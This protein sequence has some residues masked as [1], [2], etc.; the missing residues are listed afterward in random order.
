MEQATARRRIWG[1][2]FYDWAAQPFNTLIL[3]FI[4]AP[5][6]A[7]SVTMHFMES[8][9]SEESAKAQAQSL[10]SLSLTISGL[11]MAISAPIL[12]AIADGSS[13]QMRWI[14][15]FSCMHVVGA[16]A[17]WGLL[18][19][20]T[21][22][23]HA[24][25][26]FIIGYLGAELAFLFTSAQLP[27]LGS[28]KEQGKI[29]GS[30][31]AFGYLGGLIS[32]GIVL[33]FFAEQGNGKTLLGLDPA[34]GLDPELREG[35]RIAGPFV[36]I[37]FVIFAI[38]YFAWVRQEKQ[39]RS[40][41]KIKEAMRSLWQRIYTLPQNKS[42]FSYLVSSMFYRDALNGLYGFGGVYAALVLDWSIIFIGIFGVV[43]ATGAAIFSWVGGRLDAM[44][45]TKLVIIGC[46]CGLMIVCITIVFMSRSSL[47]GIPLAEGSFVPDVT[48]FI[49]GVVIGGL[50]GALQSTSRNMMSRHANPA[51]ATEYFGLYGLS[52]RATAF[53]APAMIG[54]V[55][56]VTESPRLG[57]SPLILLFAIGLFLL[58]WV[59][60]KGRVA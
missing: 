48:F 37:W 43:A 24:L 51:A 31:F 32:L 22:Y 28:R 30:G 16:F 39:A 33:L 4:F 57:V 49:C 27:N 26:A 42:L 59:E 55:T 56:L 20:G 60:P 13:R 34:F 46:I 12:G 9:L 5:F 23:M 38:P 53:L 2:Y 35:T 25:I 7:Q 52:G 6:F 10:W 11:L 15:V 1:W 41:G 17:L 45:G 50:G 36:A 3:T 29:S 44:F 47:F 14:F 8:G 54:I 19:D 58:R 21:G 40:R 18:P